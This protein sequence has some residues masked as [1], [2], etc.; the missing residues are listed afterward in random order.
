MRSLWIGLLLVGLG[1]EHG[2]GGADGGLPNGGI[3][4]SGSTAAPP[5]VVN[6]GAP[7]DEDAIAQYAREVCDAYE[8]CGPKLYPDRTSCLDMTSCSLR[9]LLIGTAL[10]RGELLACSHEFKSVACGTM[11][12][13][14]GAC[15]ELVTAFSSAL[16]EQAGCGGELCASGNFCDRSDDH[17]PRCVPYATVGQPCLDTRCE[18]GT[19]CSSTTLECE[20]EK[21][22][23]MPCDGFTECSQPSFGTDTWLTCLGGICAKPLEAGQ[24]CQQGTDCVPF[25]QCKAGVCTEPGRVGEA[26]T[27]HQDCFAYSSCIRGVC[28]ELCGYQR[29]GGPC[30]DDLFCRDSYCDEGSSACVA[31]KPAGAACARTTQ[32]GEG[33]FCNAATA[34]CAERFAD[35]MPCAVDDEC[36]SELCNGQQCQQPMCAD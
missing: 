24:A 13:V 19:Y 8:R 4:G 10:T 1:C 15:M 30:F 29:A 5:G 17:C 25:L 34:T 6:P 26:C 22:E 21:T 7:V 20:R 12:A 18:R 9:S 36:L 3:T 33:S 23:G 16:G 2:N 31:T 28:T 27:A 32:C 11:P 35:G 14:P